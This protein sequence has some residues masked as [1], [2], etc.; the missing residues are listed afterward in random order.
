M[1]Y[2]SLGKR[3]TNFCLLLAFFTLCLSA[4][5]KDIPLEPEVVETSMCLVEIN[6]VFQSVELDRVPVLIYTD[7]P[8]LL[9]EIARAAKYPTEARENGI[10][11]KATV[12]YDILV[13]GSTDNFNIIED[14]G[15]GIGESLK[16]AMKGVMTGIIFNPA[17][18]NEEFVKVRKE[19]SATYRLE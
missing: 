6:G 11:G 3:F 7:E 12:Q 10:S 1:N 5:K 14:P 4:C 19:I 2:H 8:E 13:D 9:K 17:V 16:E 18:L 15:H